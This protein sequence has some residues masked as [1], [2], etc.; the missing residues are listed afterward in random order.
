MITPPETR[1]VPSPGKDDGK[2]PNRLDVSRARCW[3]T[4]LGNYDDELASNP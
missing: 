3:R 2:L 4:A 1:V